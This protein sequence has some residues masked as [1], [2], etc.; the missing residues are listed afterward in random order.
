[1]IR[2]ND[3]YDCILLLMEGTCEVISP[4]NEISTVY[5]IFGEREVQK[6][7]KSDVTV[8]CKTDCCFLSIKK[9]NFFAS[10]RKFKFIEL[11]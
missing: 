10:L 9:S 6:C 4:L 11:K 3:F 8:R 7:I 2:I 5:G 1:V